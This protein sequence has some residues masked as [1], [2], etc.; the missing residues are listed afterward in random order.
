MRITEAGRLQNALHEAR[1]GRLLAYGAREVLLLCEQMK[2][3]LLEVERTITCSCC[4]RG[5]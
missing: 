1:L 5:G 3:G 2:R 4:D